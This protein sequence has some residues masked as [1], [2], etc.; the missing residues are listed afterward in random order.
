MNPGYLSTAYTIKHL[1]GA[2]KNIIIAEAESSFIDGRIIAPGIFRVGFRNVRNPVGIYPLYK[3][4]EAKKILDK[5]DEKIVYLDSV[6]E[7]ALNNPNL[8]VHTVGSIMSIPRI[9]QA[10]DDFCMYHEAY[11]RKNQATWRILDALDNEKM[12]I[13][14]SLGMEKLSYVNACKYRNSLDDDYDAKE[15]FL[16]YAEMETRAKGPTKVD[17][18]YISEDVPEGLV[19]LES[20]GK[21]LNINTP[22]ATSLIEV[23]SAALNRDLRREG[24][25]VSRLGYDN[26]KLILEECKIKE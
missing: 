1:R 9:E 4:E 3:L 13:L 26:I 22:I 16:E 10:E 20:L 15:V 18:R 25:T 5:L 11:T 6:V 24:R 14:D 23:A 2:N 19:M 21:L 7:A 17:S 8:I 12:Q